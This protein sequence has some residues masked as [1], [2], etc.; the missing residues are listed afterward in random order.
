MAWARSPEEL[1]HCLVFDCHIG[2]PERGGRHQHLAFSI[3][4]RLQYNKSA[5]GWVFDS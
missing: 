1:H 5:H 3:T 4:I 2:P